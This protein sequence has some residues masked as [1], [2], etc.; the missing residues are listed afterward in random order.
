LQEADA[1]IC[2]GRAEFEGARRALGHERIYQLGNG[3]HAGKFAQGDGQAFRVRQGI[4]PE[5]LVAACYSRF[6]PQKD[7]LNLLEAFDRV[8]GEFPTLYL[9]LAG[10]CTVPEYLEAIDRRI[11]ASPFAARVRRLAAIDSAAGDLV[12]AYHGCDFFVLPSRHEPFGIVVLEAWSAGKPVI[13]TA[14]GGLRDLIADGDTGLLVPPGEPAALAGALRRLLVS[15]DL[16]RRLGEAGRALA[17]KQYSWGRIAAE[18][19]H[20][21][22]AAATHAGVETETLAT[23]TC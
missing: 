15:G 14:V 11:A 23:T 10:P 7:Q 17:G 12:D 9:V 19:E 6:D 22:E 5:S 13:A 16:R 8:A 2:L 18:T 20:I 4:P 21:Y 3:V 1:V